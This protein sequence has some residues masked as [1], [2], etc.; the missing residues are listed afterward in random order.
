MLFNQRVLMHV[1]GIKEKQ[2]ANEN[3][4]SIS[5]T[6][7]IGVILTAIWN[8]GNEGK[9]MLRVSGWTAISDSAGS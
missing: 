7:Q 2:I 1:R 9:S 8:Y 4:I 3:K 6:R 5:Q